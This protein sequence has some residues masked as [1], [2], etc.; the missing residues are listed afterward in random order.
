MPLTPPNNYA[1]GSSVTLTF[2]YLNADGD[3]ADPGSG[4]IYVRHPNG[5]I[6]NTPLTSATNPSTGVYTL[7][8]VPD[9]YGFWYYRATG[10]NPT[11]A[12]LDQ[13]FNVPDSELV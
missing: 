11:S 1:I 4:N 9:A 12:S 13:Y 7:A 2:T 5:T 10:A 3:P 8:V 6:D